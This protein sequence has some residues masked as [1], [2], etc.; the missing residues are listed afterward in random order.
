M[1]LQSNVFIRKVLFTCFIFISE[2]IWPL[3]KETPL[4]FQRLSPMEK[5][6]LSDTIWKQVLLIIH[7]YYTEGL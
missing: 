3:L 4:S 2:L 7:S 1:Q 6:T 5:L